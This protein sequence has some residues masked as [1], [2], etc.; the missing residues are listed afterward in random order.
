MELT[1]KMSYI[2]GLID[3]MEIDESTKEGKAL[4]KMAEVMKE[5]TEY[6]SDLKNQIDEL[7]ELCE[8]LDE[9]LGDVEEVT[10]YMLNDFD[11]DCA[12]SCD[13]DDDDYDEFDDDDELYE[14]R[15]PSC[16]DVIYLDEEMLEEGAMECPNCGETLEFDFSEIEL[17]DSEPEK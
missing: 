15:C 8:I 12:C 6:V 7:S 5:M 1:E 2:Q 14:V 3:G 16:K 10:M 17:A 4:V 11:D 13:D 9:D